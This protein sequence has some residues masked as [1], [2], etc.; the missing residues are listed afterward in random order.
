MGG[1]GCGRP[2]WCPGR[3][4]DDY[5]DAGVTTSSLAILPLDPELDFFG[6][7]RDLSPSA[8]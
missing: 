6:A 3:R 2:A 5:F 7:V 4:I 1:V 8:T